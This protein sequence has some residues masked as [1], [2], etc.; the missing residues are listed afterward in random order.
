MAFV[1]GDPVGRYEAGVGRGGLP[2]VYVCALGL[3]V[4]PLRCQASVSEGTQG[5]SPIPGPAFSC[6]RGHPLLT[7]SLPTRLS[8]PAAPVWRGRSQVRDIHGEGVGRRCK[9]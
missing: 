8:A 6:S 2:W 7:S 9:P 3:K 4:G 5:L 1:V